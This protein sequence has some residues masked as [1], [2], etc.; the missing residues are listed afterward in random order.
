MFKQRKT[1]FILIFIVLFFFIIKFVFSFDG[2]YGQDAYEYLRYTESL[3]N[4]IKTGKNPGDYFWGI[5]YPLLGSFL[6]FI[7]GNSALALQLISL[8]SL[9]VSSVYLHK[10]I[11]LIYKEKNSVIVVFVF[12]CLSPIVLIHSFLVMS[13]MLNCALVLAC[14]YY[15]LSYLESSKKSSFLFGVAFCLLA[16]LTRYA[17][18]VILFPIGISVLLKLLKHK[19]FKLILYSIPIILAISLPHIAVKSQNSLQFLSHHWL[20]NWNIIN[21]FKSD[22][23]TIEGPRSNHFINLLYI[24]FTFFHPIFFVFGP[25]IIILFLKN[26]IRRLT[27]YQILILISVILFSLFIGGI[28]Y[29]NKRYLIPAFAFLFILIF[30]VFRCIQRFKFFKI[31]LFIV[32]IIQVLLIFYFGKQYY[33]RNLFEKRIVAEMKP[34]QNRTLYVFDIDVA[35]QGRGLH[36]RYKNLFL[37]KYTTFEKN[38]LVLLNEKQLESEWKD[39]NPLINWEN[40][41]KK[42]VLVKLKTHHKEWS[43]YE[44]INYK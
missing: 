14:M 4:Y 13:D 31:L 43:L 18:A 37:E 11:E 38:A 24:C 3:V 1:L 42:C 17:T 27:H 12:F 15:F 5:Y 44:I 26:E 23:I 32:L 2:L 25:F 40:I 36:F 10:I 33:D 19:Q 34:F 35:M 28:P 30:P 22:F 29:Q 16:I 39:K 6:T 21:L 7:V 9:L 20:Q 41:Q 8:L